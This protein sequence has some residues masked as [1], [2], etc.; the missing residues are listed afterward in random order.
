MQRAAFPEKTVANPRSQRRQ[1]RKK[2]PVL[3]HWV[4]GAKLAKKKERW[5]GVDGAWAWWR[6]KSPNSG[7]RRIGDIRATEAEEIVVSVACMP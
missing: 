6:V 5:A 1:Q 2:D 7:G 4:G 3:G